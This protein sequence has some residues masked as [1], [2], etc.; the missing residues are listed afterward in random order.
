MTK[1]LGLQSE[2]LVSSSSLNDVLDGIHMTKRQGT[3]CRKV[4]AV[5]DARG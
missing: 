1:P 5:S 4:L 2:S 3:R